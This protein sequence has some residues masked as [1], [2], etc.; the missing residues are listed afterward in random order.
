MVESF[1]GQSM[2]GVAEVWVEEDQSHEGVKLWRRL[3][4]N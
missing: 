2:I 4:L 3:D 1:D